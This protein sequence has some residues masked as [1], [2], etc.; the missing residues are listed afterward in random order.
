M[1]SNFGKTLQQKLQP[2]IACYAHSY[3]CAYRNYY[4]KVFMYLQISPLISYSLRD[5]SF[6]LS[7]HLCNSTR[8]GETLATQELRE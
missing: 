8:S 7:E 5:E 3:S 2:S 4:S 1:A 6:W